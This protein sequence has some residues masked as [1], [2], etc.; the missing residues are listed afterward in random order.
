MMNDSGTGVVDNAHRNA[1]RPLFNSMNI[2]ID[3]SN[4]AHWAL[5]FSVILLLGGILAVNVDN[6]HDS[7]LVNALTFLP[8]MALIGIGL[9]AMLTNL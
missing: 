2:T 3:F 8:T 7:L 6:A 1:H 5:F 4:P 9:Y